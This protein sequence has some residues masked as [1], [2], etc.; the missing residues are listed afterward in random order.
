MPLLT[1]ITITYNA[2]KFLPRTLQSFVVA[3]QFIKADD[4]EYLIVDGNSKDNTVEIIK[5]FEGYI[6][7]W[8]SEPDKGLYDAM[9]KGLAMATGEY[10]WFL[11]AGDE[12][13]DE[14]VLSKLLLQIDQHKSDVYYSDAMF[15]NDDG[16]AVGLRSK[17]T[18]HRLPQNLRW[19][20]MAMGMKVCHQAFIAKR[21]IAPYYDINN[22]SADIDWEIVCL[23]RSQ[24][25]IFL[26][27]LLCKYLTGGL[28][29]QKHRQSLIDRFIVLRRH[30]GLLP[31]I[32]NH[33]L[34]L[35][36]SFYHR[37]TS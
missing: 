3:R 8:I 12:M 28:S 10:V 18:P 2:E 17:I 14:N 25:T 7:H 16:S 33:V 24:K 23:Q 26:D 15:V 27:F 21:S 5:S 13:Y 22:L 29:V 34:I 30:F 6:S 19:Q 4:I 37:I 32:L 11:N 35:L 31:T 9:N 20:Q 36:R 1:I